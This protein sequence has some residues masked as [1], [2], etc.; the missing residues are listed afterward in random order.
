MQPILVVWG[1]SATTRAVK[2]THGFRIRPVR[3][4][5]T[6]EWPRHDLQPMLPEGR[7]SHAICTLEA[8]HVPLNSRFHQP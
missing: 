7:S 2:R 8:N 3:A 4:R 6:R 1:V 5:L